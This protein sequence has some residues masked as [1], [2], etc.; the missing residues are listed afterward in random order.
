MPYAAEKL[1]VI[2]SIYFMPCFALL[3][4]I[5]MA[6]TTLLV[7]KIMAKRFYWQGFWGSR[8]LQTLLRGAIHVSFLV[9]IVHCFKSYSK[10]PWK[11]SLKNQ[12]SL[13]YVLTEWSTT[14][15]FVAFFFQINVFSSISP[16]LCICNIF[17]YYFM[18][19]KTDNFLAIFCGLLLFTD[20][21]TFRLCIFTFLLEQMAIKAHLI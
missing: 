15:S 5:L 11:A 7:P 9:F 1:P 6:N 12:E 17:P 19:S 14:V 10:L 2:S 18:F 20:K 13:W 21:F 3:K 8:K 16:S 4:M